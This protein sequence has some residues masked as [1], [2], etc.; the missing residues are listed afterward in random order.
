MFVPS[1]VVGYYFIQSVDSSNLVIDVQGASTKPGTP[2]DAF[3]LK[4]KDPDWN[5]QLWTFI[6]TDGNGVTPPPYPA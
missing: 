4:T 1:T 3:T 2:L 5:N 6:D